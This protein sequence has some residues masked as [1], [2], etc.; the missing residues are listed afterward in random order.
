LFDNVFEP[1]GRDSRAAPTV[2]VNENSSST[3]RGFAEDLPDKTAV[4]YI[5]TSD[6]R[7]DDDNVICV[8]TPKPALKPKPVLVTPVVLFRSAKAPTA[9]LPPPVVL[10]S[11]A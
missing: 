2:S 11:N 1:P 5:L 3:G 4:V 10:L 6:V 9:V 8:V 7:A